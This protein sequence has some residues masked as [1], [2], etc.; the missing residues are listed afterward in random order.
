M[1]RGTGGLVLG[2]NRSPFPSGECFERKELRQSDAIVGIGSSSIAIFGPLPEFTWI[3][4]REKRF[5]L[6]AF[7]HKDR[8]SLKQ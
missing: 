5:V 7:V 2:S 6:L 4:S 8:V 1:S 3:T